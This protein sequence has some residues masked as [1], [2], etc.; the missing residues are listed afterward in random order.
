VISPFSA[1][2]V[3]NMFDPFDPHPLSRRLP[4]I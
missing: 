1:P 2:F 3:R 4:S